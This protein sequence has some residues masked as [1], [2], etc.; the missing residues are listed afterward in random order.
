M[1]Q[2]PPQNQMLILCGR[3]TAAAGGHGRPPLAIYK[4]LAKD[5][6]GF[7]GHGLANH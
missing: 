7:L 2:R 4:L 1:Q 6:E 3:W 5:V